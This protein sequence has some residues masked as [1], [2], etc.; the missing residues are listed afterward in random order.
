MKVPKFLGLTVEERR[1][2]VRKGKY[3]FCCLRTVYCK[4]GEISFLLFEDGP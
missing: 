4:K 1:S 2:V 3:C